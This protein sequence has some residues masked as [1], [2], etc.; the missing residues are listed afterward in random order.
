MQ[1]RDPQREPVFSLVFPTYNPGPVLD[2]TLPAVQRFVQEAT[3]DWEIL[4]VCDGCSDGS[5]DRLAELAQTAP[6]RIRVLSHSPNRGKG[7]SVRRGLAEARGQWRIFTD[8]DLAYGLE[9]VARAA[10]T[11]RAGADVAIASRW[12]PDSRVMMPLHLQGYVYRRHLQ[13][14][15]FSTVVR[16]LLPLTHRDTQAGLKGLSAAAAGLILPQLRCDGF[17]FDCEMLTAC[18]MNGLVISEVPVCVRYE[19]TASTTSL[20]SVGN[21]I[22][23]LWRI[24]RAWQPGPPYLSPMAG[25]TVAVANEGKAAA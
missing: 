23:E 25:R 4:F 3:D 19:D 8:I 10:D 13:S 11:L 22:R 14:Q 2:R 21:M 9:D 17:G 5:S 12:H 24:R 18:V 15:I 20:G 16:R 6:T 1:A 7:Y